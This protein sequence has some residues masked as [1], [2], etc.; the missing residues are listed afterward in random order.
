M[1][2]LLRW[3]RRKSDQPA[4]QPSPAP[5]PDP[6]PRQSPE[7]QLSPEAFLCDAL[8][9]VP[10]VLNL[11]A[12]QCPICHG[13]LEKPVLLQCAAGHMFCKPCI[14]NWFIQGYN[15]CP[16]DQEEL[17]NTE[18]RTIFQQSASLTFYKD[19]LNMYE[20]FHLTTWD[21]LEIGVS[22]QIAKSFDTFRQKILNAGE[23]SVRYDW[24]M[25]HHVAIQR[26]LD[27]LLSRF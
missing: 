3:L 15:T 20:P 12:P 26:R 24:Y 7:P 27:L 21:M 6:E 22:E 4:P 25:E 14:T 5:Q 16:R 13:K 11:P 19:L 2:E 10:A 1:R 8:I 17:F 23:H 9:A 18:S